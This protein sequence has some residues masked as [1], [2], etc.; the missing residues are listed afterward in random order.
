MGNFQFRLERFDSFWP[1]YALGQFSLFLTRTLAIRGGSKSTPPLWSCINL[2]RFRTK[3]KQLITCFR[4]KILSIGAIPSHEDEIG[5]SK[6]AS[7]NHE[8]SHLM[9]STCRLD[10]KLSISMLWRMWSSMHWQWCY[11][12]RLLVNSRTNQIADNQL[13]DWSTRGLLFI[14]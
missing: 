9:I 4:N 6:M 10:S 3:C 12:R 8:C 2:K 14:Q 13:A 7:L 5:K 1:S 11:S